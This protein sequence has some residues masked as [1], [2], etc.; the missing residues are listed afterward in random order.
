ME[1]NFLY[2]Q[3]FSHYIPARE[4][5]PFKAIKI[6]ILRSIPWQTER[7]SISY[8][9]SYRLLVVW[10]SQSSPIRHYFLFLQLDNWLCGWLFTFR[11]RFL[12]ECYAPRIQFM[13]PHKS[14]FDILG[15]KYHYPDDNSKERRDGGYS[16]QRSFSFSEN[17][18][19]YSINL[20]IL[21]F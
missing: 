20:W 1:N 7:Y 6:M 17:S 9:K 10:S 18:R 5:I 11:R 3:T 19:S 15:N 2:S 8:Y 14:F 21:K 16:V 12:L 4:N 13:L